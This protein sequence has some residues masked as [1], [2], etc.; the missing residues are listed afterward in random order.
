MRVKKSR[1]IMFIGIQ[2]IKY[3]IAEGLSLDLPGAN[4]LINKGFS[5]FKE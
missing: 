3:S 2:S 5:S 1:V 4:N